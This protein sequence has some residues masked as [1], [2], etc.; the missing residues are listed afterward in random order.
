MPAIL[1][2]GTAEVAA[3]RLFT[4]EDCPGLYRYVCHGATRIPGTIRKRA[5]DRRVGLE[6]G[7]NLEDGARTP[8][9]GSGAGGGQQEA[10]EGKHT[11]SPKANSVTQP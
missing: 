1:E 7:T 8:A 2:R 10:G 6:P 5:G 11:G 9:E 3:W 4:L